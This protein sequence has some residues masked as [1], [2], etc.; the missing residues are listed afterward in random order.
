MSIFFC[1]WEMFI[2]S[3]DWPMPKPLMV[4]A[5]ISV[6]CALVGDGGVVGGE[7]LEDVVAAAV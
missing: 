3:P 6:G 2:A 4:L 5:R 7:D 1:W